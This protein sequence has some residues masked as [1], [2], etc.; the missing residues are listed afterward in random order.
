MPTVFDHFHDDAPPMK[1]DACLPP[2]QA[3]Y[4]NACQSQ[5]VALCRPAA[6]PA[7]ATVCANPARDAVLRDAMLQAGA[8]ADG[9]S[10][11]MRGAAQRRVRR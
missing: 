1:I 4:G 7:R 3:C 8:A 9:S 6:T 10:R 11:C 5:A 2:Q